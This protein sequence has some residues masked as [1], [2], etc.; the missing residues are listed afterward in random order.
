MKYILYDFDKT[1]YDGDSSTDFFKYCLKKNKKLIKML[2]K[3]LVKFIAYKTNNIT[4]TELKEYIFSYLKYFDNIDDMVNDFW[5]IN[6]H[7]IKSFY[8]EKNHK[9]DIII[10]ASPYFLLR[11]ICKELKVKDLIASDVNPK[12]GKFNGLNNSCEEKL[13]I[14][15]KKYP[16]IVPDEM[17]S[18]SM[19]DKPLLDFAKKSFVVKKNQ[20]IDYKEY[21][22]GLIKR[23]WNFLMGIYHKKEEVWNYLIVGA[24]TTFVSIGAYA[25]FS[26]VFG[27]NYVIS[28]ILSWIV[29]VIF[30]YYTNRWFVFHSKNENVLKEFIAFISSRFLT[31][32]I[33]TGLMI[34][35]VEIMNLDDLIAKII[36]QVVVI[37]SNYV[38]SK[39]FVFKNK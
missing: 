14:F 37:V 23:I 12:T 22:P 31:L 20:I 17:Y 39:L 26:K 6:K 32:L 4:V 11:P 34:L 24:L 27:I 16:N 5:S 21:K 1:I 38:L 3:M 2:P 19:N 30:A 15:K 8:L 36:V 13:K 28:N 25:I 29:A 7:K 35:F 18:D 9:Q 10:S 33:D